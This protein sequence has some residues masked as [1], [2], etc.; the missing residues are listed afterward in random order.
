MKQAIE[1][2]YTD[3]LGFV[4]DGI[5]TRLE[6]AEKVGRM[7]TIEVVEQYREQLIYNTPVDSK[8]Q[9]LIHLAMLIALKEEGPARL[10]V[11]GALKAGASKE[12]LFAI[13]E[14]AAIVG[15]MP[16]FQRAVDLVAEGLDDAE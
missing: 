2:K 16:L 4:P 10:H 5:R 3:L 14:T 13:C 12:E 7:Q 15:G 1:Q 6:L 9:Q 11:K 8:Y